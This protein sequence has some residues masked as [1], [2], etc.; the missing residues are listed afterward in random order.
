MPID[1]PPG[2]SKGVVVL[3]GVATAL[4][5]F[6]PPPSLSLL[7]CAFLRSVP[8]SLFPFQPVLDPLLSSPLLL[9]EEIATRSRTTNR[10][11]FGSFPS[12]SIPGE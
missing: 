4:P 6:L 10:Y 2:P 7:S 8:Y 9:R 12:N 5:L 11:E 3:L 1:P